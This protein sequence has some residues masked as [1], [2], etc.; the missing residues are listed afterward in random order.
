MKRYS[1]YNYHLDYLKGKTLLY[2][3][4]SDQV[5]VVDNQLFSLFTGCA[6]DPL[7]LRDLHPQFFKSLE[8]KG[9]IIEDTVDEY[10]REVARFKEESENNRCPQITI[11]PTL[12]CNLRCWYCYESHL[13]GSRMSDAVLASVKLY[14]EKTIASDLTERMVVSFFGGEPLMY[15]REIVMPLIMFMQTLR[16]RYN[17]SIDYYMTSN[18]TLLTKDIVDSLVDNNI[19]LNLQITFDGGHEEHDKT[20]FFQDKSGSF[21]IVRNNVIYAVKSG[22]PVLVRCNYTDRNIESFK[23]LPYEFD[24]VKDM[25]N[26]EFKFHKVWQAKG[27][28]NLH[29]SLLAVKKKFSDGGYGISDQTGQRGIC[30]ADKKRNVV[31][32]Y[33]GGIYKCTARK[34]NAENS[35]GV[36][37]PEGE[38]VYNRNIDRWQDVKY[39]SEACKE[40]IIFPICGQTCIQ[41]IMESNNPFGCVANNSDKNIEKIIRSRLSTVISDI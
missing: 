4:S 6:E 32:N 8:D 40:C 7:R 33:D 15:Y 27:S 23:K 18:G 24:S 37:N 22:L 26:V 41:N 28:E 9:F 14:L 35:V 36:L 1:K 10:E 3:T 30:Y 2:N 5:L 13:N 17:K 34:F 29:E 31:I 19:R 21:A 11:N 25:E 38:I 39:K 16:E 20:K 12:D